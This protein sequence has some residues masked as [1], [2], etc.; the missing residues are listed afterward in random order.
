MIVPDV[1]LLVYAYNESSPMHHEA[2]DWW[3]GVLE[4][5]EEVGLPWAVSMGFVRLMANPIVINPPV[6]PDI[7]LG[8]VQEWLDRPH[9]FEIHPG[10]DHIRVMRR[11]VGSDRTSRNV[12]TDA[13]I[14]ALAI[15]NDA[16]IHSKDAKFS[17][18]PG[19]KWHDPLQ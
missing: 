3:N 11:I 9:I 6:A 16:E 7:S 4:G 10:A 17:Q 14:A 19:L 5:S 12:V 1:N 2:K 15:E 13:H 18:F 8:R